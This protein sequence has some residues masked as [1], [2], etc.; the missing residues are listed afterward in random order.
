MKLLS[1]W[2]P[3]L[4]AYLENRP[5]NAMYLSNRAQNDMIISLSAR[6]LE[7]IKESVKRDQFYSILMDETADVSSKEQVVYKT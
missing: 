2:E 7:K 6:V 4:K 1:R 5:R 3:C